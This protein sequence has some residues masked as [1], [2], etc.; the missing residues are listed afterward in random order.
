M[1]V[2]NDSLKMTLSMTEL[3]RATC[4]WNVHFHLKMMVTEAQNIQFLY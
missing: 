4:Q 3:G 1:L 2:Q